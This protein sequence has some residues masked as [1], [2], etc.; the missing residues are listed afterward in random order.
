[1]KYKCEWFI[2]YFKVYSLENSSQFSNNK[3]NE[4]KI[5]EINK[6]IKQEN[7]Y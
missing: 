5:Y 4:F 2:N 1:M 3:Q 6:F 7:I